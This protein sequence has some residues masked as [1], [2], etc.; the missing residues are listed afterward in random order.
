MKTLSFTHATDD[1]LVADVPRL[2]QNERT[3]TADFVACLAEFDGRRL[4]LGLGFA[5][6]YSYCAARLHLTEGAA[7]RRV[8]TARASRRFPI[9]LEMLRDGQLSLA[10]AAL[11]G[12]KLTA[13]NV[14]SLLREVAF[15]SKREVEVILAK[16]SPRPLA[17]SVV[18]KLPDPKPAIIAPTRASNESPVSLTE[19]IAA[20][21]PPSRRP[22]VAPLSEAH[23]KLQVTISTAARERLAQ[24]QDLMRHRIPG[25]DPAAIVEHALE[26]LHMELLKK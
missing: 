9:V 10:T 4:Y 21:P 13:G 5:S 14:E 25:G 8:E 7:Y 20:P 3:S 26:V 1:Q 18:R 16:R 6:I 11:I 23:Y 22:I 12:Q 19:L 17:P 2:A 15:K 24:I